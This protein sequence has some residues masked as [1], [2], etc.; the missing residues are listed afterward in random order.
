[1]AITSDA[2]NAVA[3]CTAI[4]PIAVAAPITR[5]LL[6][7]VNP[8]CVTSASYSVANPT[9]SAAASLQDADSGSAIA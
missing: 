1:M 7:A 8:A 5:T 2:P 4:N 9:G 3:S 6:P